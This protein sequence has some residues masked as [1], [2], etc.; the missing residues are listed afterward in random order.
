MQAAR[1]LVFLAWVGL[2]LM[3]GDDEPGYAL[4][5][6]ITY[7][8]SI[9]S[10]P[11][12][13]KSAFQD[14][15]QVFTSAYSDPMTINISVGWGELAGLGLSPPNIGQSIANQTPSLPIP[16]CRQRLSTMP[17]PLQTRQRLRVYRPP[18]PPGV[19]TSSCRGP[20][21]RLWAW[22]QATRQQSMA[23]WGLAP[24]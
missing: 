1:V 5:F 10:A 7:D 24:P 12:G 2:G 9:D 15:T 14:A 19:P 3:L 21:L 4:V 20:R 22:S 11:A 6:N 13:L 18:I 8:S 16:R 23:L 17:R